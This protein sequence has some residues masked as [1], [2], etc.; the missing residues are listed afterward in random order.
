V[1][2]ASGGAMPV[3]KQEFS[4]KDIKLE[5]ALAAIQESDSDEDEEE[6]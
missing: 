4:A 2:K 5:K 1:W 6:D 3:F